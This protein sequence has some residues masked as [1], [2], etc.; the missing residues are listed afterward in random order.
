MEVFKSV[1]NPNAKCHNCQAKFKLK[2][3]RKCIICSNPYAEFLFCK[4]CSI[5]ENHHSLGFLAPKR[6]CINCYST[7]CT[8]SPKKDLTKSA[9]LSSR[10]ESSDQSRPDLTKSTTLTSA[11]PEPL[12]SA[13][14]ESKEDHQSPESLP[15]RARVTHK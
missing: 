8:N 11:P 3:R 10:T 12:C 6:Y 2:R 4:K 9:S 5:K 7:A 13:P 15:S 14:E 1:F